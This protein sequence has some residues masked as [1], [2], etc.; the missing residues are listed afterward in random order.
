VVFI[1]SGK[2]PNL[3]FCWWR[4]PDYPEKTAGLSQIT[5]N[6]Q[7]RDT[8]NIGKTRKRDTDKNT[9]TTPRKY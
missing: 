6:G 9:H 3:Q 7:S 2:V 5:K 8:G 1:D 4:K